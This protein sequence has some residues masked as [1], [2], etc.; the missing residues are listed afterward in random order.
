MKKLRID[1]KVE[2]PRAMPEDAPKP[3]G[4]KKEKKVLK[5]AS[6][7]TDM[8]EVLDMGVQTQDMGRVRVLT[9]TE[10]RWMRR[11]R[12]QLSREQVFC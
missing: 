4:Q 1:G 9:K 12:L 10:K 7:Q 6:V 2:V 8:P 11:R 3:R 5:E